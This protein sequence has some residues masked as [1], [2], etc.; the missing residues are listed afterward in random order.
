MQTAYEVAPVAVN[1]AAIC[2]PLSGS[3][4]VFAFCILH[5]ALAVAVYE[6]ACVEGTSGVDTIGFSVK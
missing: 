1:A 6:E 4:G 5:F 3:W 2:T